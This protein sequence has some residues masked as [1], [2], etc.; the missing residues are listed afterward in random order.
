M[1]HEKEDARKKGQSVEGAY[2]G[3]IRK[4][5]GKGKSR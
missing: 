5:E 1:V 3:Q 4:N 2:R